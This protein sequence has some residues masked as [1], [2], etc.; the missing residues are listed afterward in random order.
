[1]I[2]EILINL[3]TPQQ[4]AVIIFISVNITI[5]KETQTFIVTFKCSLKTQT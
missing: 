3:K 1:M 4:E 2:V 5:S